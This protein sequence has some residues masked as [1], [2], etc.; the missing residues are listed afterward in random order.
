MEKSDLHVREGTNTR[1]SAPDK[2]WEILGL[3]DTEKLRDFV[4]K[5][6]ARSLA[7]VLD[8]STLY[9]LCFMDAER[10]RLLE[11]NF[12]GCL[13]LIPFNAAFLCGNTYVLEFNKD[14]Y[15]GS[16]AGEILISSADGVFYDIITQQYMKSESSERK[17]CRS[18]KW[19]ADNDLKWPKVMLMERDFQRNPEDL[20]N[21]VLNPIENDVEEQKIMYEY[22][23][24]GGMGG[25]LAEAVK[26]HPKSMV[27]FKTILE[28]FYKA[29]DQQD[30]L[31]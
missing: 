18:L 4:K 24:V 19:M 27:Q 31:I 13:S 22:F 14:R 7:E 20:F 15:F 1:T 21:E 6:G 10:L 29:K 2:L 23:D 3:L 25:K 9:G 8:E 28:A 16:N 17:I 30:E 5:T 12:P 26:L 11:E